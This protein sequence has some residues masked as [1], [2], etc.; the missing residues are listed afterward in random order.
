MDVLAFGSS[1][2]EGRIAIGK[3]RNKGHNPLFRAIFSNYP[4]SVRDIELLT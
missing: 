2:F 1:T 4:I 3:L